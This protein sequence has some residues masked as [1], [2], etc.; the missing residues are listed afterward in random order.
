HP[1]RSSDVDDHPLKGLYR[2][3]PYSRSILG[4]VGDPIRL[5]LITPKDGQTKISGILREI[6]ARHMPR[7][8]RAYL[9]DFKGFSATFGVR[10][11]LDAG[12]T[13]VLP[14]ELDAE[15]ANA[16]QPHRLLADHLTRA[17]SAVRS[18]RSEF[19]VLVI[20][21]PERWRAG[22]VGGSNED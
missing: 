6:E 13:V 7:E 5:A 11:V 20:Y 2:F 10:V 16:P 18:R 12:L 22:F 1:E 9:I 19:D 3:G 17:I 14:D 8:R 15:M 21:L 4:A